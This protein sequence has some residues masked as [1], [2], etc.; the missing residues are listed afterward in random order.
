MSV[1]SLRLM[2]TSLWPLAF[3]SAAISER[4]QHPQRVAGGGGRLQLEARPPSPPLRTPP[5]DAEGA[6]PEATVRVVKRAR[7]GG[8]VAHPQGRLRHRRRRRLA[9]RTADRQLARQEGLARVPHLQRGLRVDSPSGRADSPSRREESQ[10][11]VCARYSAVAE[12]SVI[13]CTMTR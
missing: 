12:R 2:R 1:C 13:R 4:A 3:A 9:G 7:R 11:T 6:H 5:R 10:C 8:G